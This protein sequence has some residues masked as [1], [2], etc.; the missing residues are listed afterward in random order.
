MN[1][2][3]EIKRCGFFSAIKLLIFDPTSLGFIEKDIVTIFEKEFF[4]KCRRIGLNEGLKYLEDTN[5]YIENK[6]NVK[7][8]CSVKMDQFMSKVL[9]CCQDVKSIREFFLFLKKNKKENK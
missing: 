6:V 5:T 7:N 1:R 8:Y 2:H 4:D 3:T 9:T